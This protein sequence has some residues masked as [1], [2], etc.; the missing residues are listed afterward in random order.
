MKIYQ[1]KRC[2]K[3]FNKKSHLYDHLNKKNSCLTGIFDESI[4]PKETN[5]VIIIKENIYECNFCNKN[6]SR[7]D[8]LNRHI[9]EYCKEKKIQKTKIDKLEDELR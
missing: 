4:Y 1:C 3:E 9:E 8:S 5:E 7:I 2:L 6:F